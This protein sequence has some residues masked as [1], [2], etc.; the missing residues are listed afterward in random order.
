MPVHPWPAAPSQQHCLVE[1]DGLYV[2]SSCIVSM[3]TS[4]LWWTHCC[5]GLT[6]EGTCNNGDCIA[7]SEH[8]KGW[9]GKTSVHNEFGIH[10]PNEDV[11]YGQARCR[12]CHYT[13]EPERFVFLDCSA[14]VSFCVKGRI[15]S[16]VQVS[17]AGQDEAVVLGK[18]GQKITCTSLVIDV[19]PVGVYKDGRSVVE[20]PPAEQA[21]LARS[22]SPLSLSRV[23]VLQPPAHE[24]MDPADIHYIQ[25]SIANIFRCGRVVCDTMEKLRRKEISP[26]DIS[27][28]MV[29]EMRGRIHTSDNRRLWAFKNAGVTSVPV[30]RILQSNVDPDKFTTTNNGLSIR[31]RGGR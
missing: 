2:R 6:Y 24:E 22:E 19:Q 20:L 29:F 15:P 5:R 12:A 25:D 16:H 14:E 31:M 7:W 26:N 30:L 13:F 23:G 10:R 1:F 27:P 9:M 18:R 4:Q 8:E 17:H 21:R 11:D 28:I 3:Q